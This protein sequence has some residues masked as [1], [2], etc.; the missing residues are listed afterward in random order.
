MLP[1]RTNWTGDKPV[2]QKR[3]WHGPCGRWRHK[4]RV[5]LYAMAS[6]R[7]WT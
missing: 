2:T 3:K 4:G 1:D 5:V 6:R 7:C